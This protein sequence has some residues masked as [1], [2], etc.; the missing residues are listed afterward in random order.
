MLVYLNEGYK[1]GETL[2]TRTGFKFAGRRGD[3]LL[4]RNARSGAIPDPDAEHAGLP[5]LSGDKVIA[6]RWIREKP[7]ATG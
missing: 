2:F 5:V 4:F 6:S 3:G 7:I 1:G